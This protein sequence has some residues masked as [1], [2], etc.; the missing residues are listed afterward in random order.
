MLFVVLAENRLIFEGGHSQRDV[1]CA[2]RVGWADEWDLA[3]KGVLS[4]CQDEP[5]VAVMAP[6]TGTID[7]HR[8]CG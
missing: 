5:Q 2:T 4:R 1:E 3:D 7:Q 6:A 8:V